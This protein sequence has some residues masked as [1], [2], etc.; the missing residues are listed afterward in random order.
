M[1]QDYSSFTDEE[2]IAQL[3]EGDES[4]TEYLIIKYKNLVRSRASTMYILGGDK[5]DLLQ[6]GMIGLVK[7]IRDY[8]F[9]RD[10]CFLT[11]AELCINRQLYNAVQASQRKKHSFLNTYVSLNQEVAENG[12]TSTVQQIIER[13]ESPIPNPEDLLIDHENLKQLEAYLAETLSPFEQEVLGLY[14][15]GMDYVTIAKVLGKSEKSTDNALQRIKTKIR[16][17][18]DF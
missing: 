3:R 12:E 13:L 7:A 2:L 1:A 5:D 6:E 14:I 15:T 18:A 8:D 4:I 17:K 10:A 9:G 11:F 16:K